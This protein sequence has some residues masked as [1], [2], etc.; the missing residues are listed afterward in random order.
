[1]FEAQAFAIHA[2]DVPLQ[3][4]ALL[5]AP[6]VDVEALL[7]RKDVTSEPPLPPSAAPVAS[8]DSPAPATAT[9]P[10]PPL[11][12]ADAEASLLPKSHLHSAPTLALEAPADQWLHRSLAL[13]LVV[14]LCL[15][16][17]V[18]FRD[19]LA[20]R[21]PASQPIL[22]ALCM[23]ANCDLKPLRRWNGIVIDGSSL[24]RGDAGYTLNVTLR[25][26]VEVPLAMTAMEMTLTDDQDRPLLR[27]VLS[28][29]DLGAPAVLAAG[30]AWQRALKVEFNSTEADIAGYRLV[31]FYP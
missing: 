11:L 6:R 8:R 26:S 7:R 1:V 10:S 15:Q 14:G 21:L 30:Q 12:N 24:V 25:N 2:P 5:A 19:E 13:L 4:D 31:S 23:P 9:A 20:A 18:F 22:S 27:R 29:S 17:L 16:A 3:A 28:P